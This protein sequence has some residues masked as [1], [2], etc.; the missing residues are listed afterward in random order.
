MLEIGH[1]LEKDGYEYCLIDFFNYTNKVYALFSVEADKI[2]YI[3]YEVF[4]SENEYSL[5]MVED[6]NLNFKLLELFENK[7]EV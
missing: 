4:E 1:I 2:S 6:D 7:M 5:K 3:F